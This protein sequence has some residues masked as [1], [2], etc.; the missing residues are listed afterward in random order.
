MRPAI[1]PAREMTTAWLTEVLAEAGIGAIRSGSDAVIES[2][3]LTSIGTGQ[4]GE[5]VRFVL[6]WSSDDPSLPKTVVGKFPSQSEISRG[7][8]ALTGTYVHEVGFYRDL[9]AGVAICV[10]T[11]HY[12]AGDPEANDF[13]LIMQDIRGAEQGDQL[14]GCTVEQAEL[15]VDQAAALHGPTWAATSDLLSLD[16][17]IAPD[18][19]RAKGRC[20]LY[21]MV[22]DGFANRYAEVMS[23][24]DIELGRTMIGHLM[25]LAEATIG[26]VDSSNADQALCLT[27]N[28]YRLDNMLFGVEPGSASLTVV[29]WQTVGIGSGPTDLAYMLGSGLLPDIRVEHEQ[30]LVQ[31]YIDGLTAHGTEVPFDAIWDRYVLGSF[32]GYLMA[33]TA[34]QI[35]EQTERGDAMFV[36]MAVRHAEQMRQLG[37]LERLGVTHH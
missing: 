10:P 32:S 16:W 22:F 9:A 37:F 35:V 5:N 28:D 14:A 25:T 31:R 21:Q 1:V 30:R 13:V 17:V 23:A 7:T 19:N 8:A 2:M 24:E 3:D 29:D 34:S 20:D 4:V 33:V 36:A 15:A 11:V 26:S 12:A 27:H 6:T 18:L